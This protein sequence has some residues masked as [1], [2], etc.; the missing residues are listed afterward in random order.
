[1]QQPAHTTE[2]QVVGEIDARRIADA[3]AAA[4]RERE[5]SAAE[6][7]ARPKDTQAAATPAGDEAEEATP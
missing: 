4:V 5:S 6:R 2:A 3:E 7:K 1:M